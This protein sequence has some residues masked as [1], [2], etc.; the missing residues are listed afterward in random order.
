MSRLVRIKTRTKKSQ[1]LFLSLV[2]ARTV[3]LSVVHRKIAPPVSGVIGVHLVFAQRNAMALK[4]A[5]VRVHVLVQLLNSN[6]R[7][8]NVQPKKHT[9]EKVV[10]NAHAM[11]PLVKRHAVFNVL[12]H[13]IFARSYPMIHL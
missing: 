9:T 10:L 8:K 1:N 3:V 7:I 13:Q 12:L 5:T 4:D 2:Y 11:Q 6:M